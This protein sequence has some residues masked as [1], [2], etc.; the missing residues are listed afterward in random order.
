MK[1]TLVNTTRANPLALD[2]IE[3][4]E[5]WLIQYGVNYNSTRF[6]KVI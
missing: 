2:Q 6:G 3:N 4:V 5:R 1:T